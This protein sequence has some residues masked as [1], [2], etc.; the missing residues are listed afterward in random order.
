MEV[1][2]EEEEEEKE[3][4]EEEEEENGS[5]SYLNENFSVSKVFR[6]IGRCRCVLIC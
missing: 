2:K 1:W 4:E 3:E 6:F 5:N